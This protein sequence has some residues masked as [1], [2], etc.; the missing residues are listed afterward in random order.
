MADFFT[1][2]TNPVQQTSLA[3]MMNLASGVQNYQQAQQLNPLALQAKQLEL[4]QNQQLLQQRQLEYKKL[5]E[6]YGPDVARVI[7]E[8]QRAGTEAD[9]SAQT[10]KPRIATAG[11]QASTAESQAKSAGIKVDTDTAKRFIEMHEVA[12]GNLLPIAIK[13]D[14]SYQDLVNSMTKTLDAL[15]VPDD[16]RKQSMAQIPDFL[17]NAS[18]SKIQAFAAQEASKSLS[19]KD[20]FESFV[21]TPKIAVSDTGRTAVTTTGAFATPT[22][23]VG[24]AQG[25]QG[26]ETPPELPTKPQQSVSPLDM[27]GAFGLSAPIAAPFP[28]RSTQQYIPLQGEPEAQA[29]GIKLRTALTNGLNNT[30]DMNRN[31]EESFKAITKLDPGSFYTSG[32]IGT[33]VRNAKS[34]FGSSDY[35][36][37]SKDLAN[38]QIAQMQAN[39]GSLDT[40]AGQGLQAKAT[41]T[42]TYNPD[43]LLNIMQRIDANKTELQLKAPAA[44]LF[45][46]KYGDNNMA[47]FQ[48]EWSK[49]ADSKVF[50]AINIFHNVTDP[51]EQKAQI[52]NLFGFD[53]PKNA[54][55]DQIKAI[56]KKRKLFAEKYDNIQKLITK[57]SLD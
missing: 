46:Q 52:D 42:E 49:N 13:K 22:A 29:N 30:A 48:Q 45:S 9:V 19:A 24:T 28:K 21:P 43:V 34:L 53:L 20:R 17:K 47:K 16:V 18:S 38:L 2:Y 31:V 51:K 23:T 7:A 26:G 1:G 12:A 15:N 50:Q 3:D 37:L 5:Q 32:A 11:S 6:T 8:S 25:M 44:N 10:A 14:A 40:V 35:Q 4:Q 56:N 27:G 36:Q 39:G 57:G 41:G 33:V 55:Q 54:T